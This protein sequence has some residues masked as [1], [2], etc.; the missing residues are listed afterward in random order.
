[1]STSHVLQRPGATISYAINGKGPLLL[2]VTG[3]SGDGAIFQPIAP[4]LASSYTVCTWARRG[5]SASKFTEDSPNLSPEYRLATD[6]DDAAALIAHLSPSTPAYVLGSS[7][8][9]IVSLTL[10]QRH[11]DSVNFLI[12][13]EPPLTK[14]L[15]AEGAQVLGAFQAV[16]DTY[17]QQGI[18]PAI[19]MFKGALASPGSSEYEFAAQMGTPENE[20]N[21]RFFFENELAK[22]TAAEVDVA[23]LKA[24][25]SKG[26]VTLVHGLE[27]E[28]PFF[29]AVVAKLGGEI[30]VQI[31]G[32]PGGHLGFA[33]KPKEFA[34]EVRKLLGAAT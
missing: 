31:Q 27:T 12:A 7:S 3:A 10:L 20:P 29:Q 34:V 18:P 19:A 21:L 5:Y 14:V 22:Y 16:T 17:T 1:M 2:C 24:E 15:G 28:N 8:G 4:E 32:M 25:A 33:S 11:P 9:A 6:A 13:H 30:G 23:K 26:K